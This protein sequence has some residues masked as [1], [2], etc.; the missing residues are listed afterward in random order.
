[1]TNQ[2]KA[3]ATTNNNR[4]YIDIIMNCGRMIQYTA[5]MRKEEQEGECVYLQW[6]SGVCY[7]N[8]IYQ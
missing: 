3:T 5:R 2:Q 1:M 8:T 4:I 7:K 6:A